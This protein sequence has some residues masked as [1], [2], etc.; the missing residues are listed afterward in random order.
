MGNINLLPKDL[1]RILI[2]KNLLTSYYLTN[3]FE[4]I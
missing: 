1:N 3:Y 4:V 2:Y